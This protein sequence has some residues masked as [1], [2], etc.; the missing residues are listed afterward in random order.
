[1]FV[2]NIITSHLS[3]L[4][5]LSDKD[6]T[7]LINYLLLILLIMKTQENERKSVECYKEAF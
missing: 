1:M 5:T 2:S 6:K 3:H 4:L 7:W